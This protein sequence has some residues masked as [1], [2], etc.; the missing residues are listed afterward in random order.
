[1]KLPKAARLRRRREYLAVQERGARL[2][3]GELLVLF[4]GAKL[5]QLARSLGSAQR[6]FKKGLADGDEAKKDSSNSSDP[7]AP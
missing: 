4:G 1:M 2:Y 6:E 7:T 5:P 3:S